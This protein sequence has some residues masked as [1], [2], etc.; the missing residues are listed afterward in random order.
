M[1]VAVLTLLQSSTSDLLSL[2]RTS[3]AY[4]A[5][6]V[7]SQLLFVLGKGI[8]QRLSHYSTLDVRDSGGTSVTLSQQEEGAEGYAT[9]STTEQIKEMLIAAAAV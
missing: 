1:G 9:G 8:A 5:L 6:L 3:L 7:N 2:I 4:R